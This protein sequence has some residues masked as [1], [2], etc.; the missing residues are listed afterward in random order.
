MARPATDI[1]PRL[2]AAARQHFLAQGVDGASLR[3]IAR[4]AQT[5][6]GMIHYYFRTKDELFFAV[7]EEVYGVLL[8]D[9][10]EALDPGQP[11][12]ERLRQLYLRLARASELEMQTVR[13]VLLEAI[14]S[15]D[16]LKRIVER[17]R[18]GHLPLLLRTIIDGVSEGRFNAHHH[19]AL[20]MLV[21]MGG[22]AVPQLLRRGLGD[23]PELDGLPRGEEL[24]EEL[25]KLV[26]SGI[27]RGP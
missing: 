5:N 4:D 10:R 26:L 7:V 17:F 22:G 9:L 3:G 21:A 1:R 8:A 25:L 19:P 15:S 14:R 13:L 11:P 27:G 23:Q 20:L 16:R 6:I 2:I 18:D 12:E 24:A